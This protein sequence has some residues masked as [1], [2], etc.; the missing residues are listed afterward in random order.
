MVQAEYKAEC[1][2]CEDEF[3]YTEGEVETYKVKQDK[4]M[5]LVWCPHCLRSNV[6]VSHTQEED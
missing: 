5:K 4:E 1:E 3:N 2:W 6:P